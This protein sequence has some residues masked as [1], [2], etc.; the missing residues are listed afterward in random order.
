[1]TAGAAG[2]DELVEQAIA[3]VRRGDLQAARDVLEDAIRHDPRHV[4]AA[5]RLLD[6]TLRQHGAARAH[7]TYLSR[8]AGLG[9]AE[10]DARWLR[11]AFAAGVLADPPSGLRIAPQDTALRWAERSGVEALRLGEVEQIPIQAIGAAAPTGHVAGNPP[12]VVDLPDVEVF[13]YSHAVL[14]A[15]GVALNEAGGHP[16]YGRFVDHRS[17]A[18]V[19]AQ[20]D[21]RLLLRTGAYRMEDLDA[22]VWLAG[23]ASDAF[24]HWIGE[25]LPRLEFLERHPAFAGRPI[26][27]DEAMPA[28]HREALAMIC[29]NPLIVLPRGQGLRVRRLLYAP[30][31]TFF[32]IHLIPGAEL[33]PFT[34][35]CAS[36]RSYRFLRARAEQALGVAPPTG[37]KYYLSRAGR[38]WRRIRNED[39]VRGHLEAQGY[40]TVMA[41][42][43][44]F[45]E[46]V[47]L[48]QG[49]GA[50][51]APT[52]SAMQNFIYAPTDVRLVVLTQAN[53]HNHAAFN[54][55]A[56][57]L[58]YDPRFVCG[59]AVGDPAQKHVDYVIPIP[60]LAAET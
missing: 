6:V 15:D 34:A 36:V 39:E 4:Q 17:D 2:A 18:A 50:I 21:G 5:L 55:Q 11:A 47:R 8:F 32:P 23:P 46:Q 14:T 37:A 10:V 51:V 25:F 7:E 20:R 60:A 44:S 3:A 54:G 16:D 38:S 59:E 27:V 35:C 26:I 45:A 53:L 56:R 22:G 42:D 12:Y 29:R 31:P 13:A 9:L 30:T 52:G 40:R 28:T 49:A 33:P 57:A 24:G 19:M 48:F 1:M 43:L 41:E 58:G